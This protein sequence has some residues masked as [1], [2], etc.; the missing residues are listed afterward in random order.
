MTILVTG[1]GGFVGNHIFNSIKGDKVGIQR[2]IGKRTVNGGTVAIGDLRNYDF[3]NRVVLEY[4]PD[5]V[6][7][8][9]ASAIVNQGLQ[10][11]SEM[12][13]SNLIGTLNLLEACKK[14]NNKN[15]YF[16]YFSTDKVLGDLQGGREDDPYPW[17]KMGPYEQSKAMSELLCSRYHE[18]FRLCTTRSPNIYGPGDKSNRIIPNGIRRV[19]SGKNPQAYNADVR[20]YIYV[21]DVVRAITFLWQNEARGTWHLGTP[22]I[23]TSVQVCEQIVKSSA[24]DLKVDLEIDNVAA[25]HHFLYYIHNQYLNYEKL[26]K[27]GWEPEMSFAEGIGKTI[28]WWWQFF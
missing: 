12:Y 7:H 20:Q 26:K 27:F 19:L 6:I 17:T 11:P 10:N 14:L 25:S 22:D 21:E 18:F 2:D 8:V 16:L 4:E 15:L 24:M 13:S 23:L 28:M 1:S 5:T 3:V 9:A